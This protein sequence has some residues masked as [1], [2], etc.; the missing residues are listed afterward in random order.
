MAIIAT[1]DLHRLLEYHSRR[2]VNAMS[3]EE[4]REY[5]EEKTILEYLDNTGNMSEYTEETLFSDMLR[6]ENG[7]TDAVYQF[8]VESGISS[9]YADTVVQHYMA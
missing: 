7:D 6:H 4:L 9:A 3:V 2:V 5:A 8:M 1:L